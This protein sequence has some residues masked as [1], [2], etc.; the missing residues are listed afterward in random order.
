LFSDD[1]WSATMIEREDHLRAA[2]RR[3]LLEAN[4]RHGSRTWVQATGASMWP[5]IVP[6]DWIRVDGGRAPLVGD[7]VV[8]AVGTRLVAHRLVARHGTGRRAL[9]VTKG[10]AEAWADPPV[11][12]HAVLGVVGAVRHER[13]GRASSAGLTGRP[14]RALARLSGA[15]GR[16]LT[17]AHDAARALPRPLRAPVLRAMGGLACLPVELSAAVLLMGARILA[18]TRKEVN[19]TWRPTRAPRSS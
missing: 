9:L 5:L 6:G 13:T 10:D 4:G 14:A 8:V 1:L 11:Q 2:A 18:D 17:P 7:V 15:A 19:H 12:A 16:H 3:A